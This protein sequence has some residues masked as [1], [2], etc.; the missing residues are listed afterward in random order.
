[1]EGLHREIDWLKCGWMIVYEAQGLD[2]GIEC[3]LMV[4]WTAVCKTQG[5]HRGTNSGAPVR[6]TTVHA[7]QGLDCRYSVTPPRQAGLNETRF[8]D[9]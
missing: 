9:R 3:G 8:R 1:M 5:F 4:R 2:R 6:W 7:S